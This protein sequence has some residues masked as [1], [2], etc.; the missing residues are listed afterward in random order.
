M[1]KYKDKIFEQLNS[2]PIQFVFDDG[3]REAVKDLG[4]VYRKAEL[5][6]EALDMLEHKTDEEI[7]WYVLRKFREIE[8]R[9]MKNENK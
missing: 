6:D 1:N 8:S 7:R 5:L 2:D 9:R 3:F 4:K